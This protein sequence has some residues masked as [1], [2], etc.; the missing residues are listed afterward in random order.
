MKKP[1]RNRNRNITFVIHPTQY[2]DYDILAIGDCSLLRILIKKCEHSQLIKKS[3]F[4]GIP[5]LIL[6]TC[7]TLRESLSCIKHYKKLY[8]IEE[9]AY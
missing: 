9:N 2:Q 1:I 4:G 8:A 5:I 7:D 3:K 6:D